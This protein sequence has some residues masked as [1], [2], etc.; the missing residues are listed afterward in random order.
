MDHDVSI[1]HYYVTRHNVKNYVMTRLSRFRIS[2][3]DYLVCTLQ[4]MIHQD[5]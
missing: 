2:K 3:T 1:C 4:P 5:P